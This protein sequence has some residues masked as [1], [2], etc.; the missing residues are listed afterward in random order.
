MYVR[1]GRVGQ[2]TCSLLP[3]GKR[4]NVIYR[5]DE[6]IARQPVR[7]EEGVGETP[8][9]H[10]RAQSA[11]PRPADPPGRQAL[12]GRGLTGAMR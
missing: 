1:S 3:R 2:G 7:L 6:R 9:S 11:R 5:N 8:R 12:D 4:Y 10:P